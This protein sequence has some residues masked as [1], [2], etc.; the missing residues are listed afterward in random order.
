ML[1]QHHYKLK[2]TWTGNNG[3]GTDHY[4]HYE[5]S[6]NIEVDHKIK[7]EASSDAPFLGDATKH[8][9]EDFFLSSL[10]TC[11]MLWYL[12]LCADAGIIVTAYF[13]QPTGILTQNQDGGGSFTEVTLHPQVTV[14]EEHM[15]PTAIQLHEKAN[16]KCF[17]ANSVN[18][19]IKHSPTC[20]SEN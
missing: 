17:I 16:Q 13:D 15:I 10:S 12:H 5:R 14:K 6:H 11:H 4:T 3:T 8:N 19:K 20:V 1:K 7:I 2:V 18:F 9:P